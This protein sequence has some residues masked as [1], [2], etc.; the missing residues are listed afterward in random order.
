MYHFKFTVNKE[1][2][3]VSTDKSLEKIY[4]RY[5]NS[6]TGIPYFEVMPKIIKDD[7][8]AV[9]HV[10]DGGT[11][12]ELKEYKAPCLCGLS[13]ADISIFPIRDRKMEVTGAE[14]TVSV[15]PD[16]VLSSAI[17]ESKILIDIG[18][19]SASLAHGV[20]SPLNAIKGAIIYLQ[21]KYNDDPIFLEFSRIIEEEITK[22]DKFVTKFLSSSLSDK[23]IAEIDVNL[24]LEEILKMLNLQ[25]GTKKI[26]LNK[27]CKDIPVIKAE[28]F[29]FKHAILNIINNSIEATQE[30]G[31]I[32]IKTFLSRFSQKDYVTIQISDS[33]YGFSGID[34]SQA[35]KEESVKS[36]RGFGLF[37]THEIVKNLGGYL[38]IKSEKMVGTTININIPAE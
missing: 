29:Q 11:P 30:G 14:V 32:H 28:P 23:E 33:G 12:L 31:F 35:L 8:D 17:N 2:K 10:I 26:T 9:K 22:L 25:A 16:C 1:L 4:S 27:E 34:G 36:G 18:K 24:L 38:E 20:R 19:T 5:G 7:V 21:G 6:S 15:D 37:I 13:K 3:I